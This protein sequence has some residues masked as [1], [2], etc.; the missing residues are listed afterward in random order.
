[1]RPH[2][3]DGAMTRP[4]E[5][6]ALTHY[7]TS[8]TDYCPRRRNPRDGCYCVLEG[9]PAPPQPLRSRM[10]MAVMRA[11]IPL[12][13]RIRIHAYLRTTKPSPPEPPDWID[14]AALKAALGAPGGPDGCR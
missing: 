12:K 10:A 3:E 1:M 7:D 2:M 4:A 14:L 8:H 11:P 6:E 9:P 5:G 13:L